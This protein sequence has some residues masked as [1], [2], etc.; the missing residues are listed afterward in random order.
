MVRALLD[1]D[2]PA[3]AGGGVGDG[4]GEAGS[5]GG[6]AGSLYVVKPKMH[7]PEEAAFAGR[8]FDRAEDAYK[9]LA[10]T[11]FDTLRTLEASARGK[12]AQAGGVPF[13][14]YRADAAEFERRGT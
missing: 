8:L 12:A 14:A 5:A 7:G 3:G 1:P 2:E 4:S 9:A 10:G 13:I 11:S 6:P